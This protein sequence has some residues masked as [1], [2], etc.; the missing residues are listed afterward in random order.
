MYSG[1]SFLYAIVQGSN[2]LALA[3]RTGIIH[4][5]LAL[6]TGIKHI[7]LALRTGILHNL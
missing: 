1:V 2:I 6:T 5:T 3:Q 7:T 4:M